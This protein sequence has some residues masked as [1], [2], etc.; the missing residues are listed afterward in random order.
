M[1]CPDSPANV[2]DLLF[3]QSDGLHSEPNRPGADPTRSAGDT[4]MNV[5]D[6][7]VIV[8]IGYCLVRGIFRGLIKE[9]SAIVGVLAGFW[10]AYS[11]YPT[12]ARPLGRWISDPAY[13]NILGFMILFCGVF[14][15]VS[16]VGVVIKYL[17]RVA[18]LGWLDRIC[19]AAFG[20]FKGVLI[21][22]VVLMALTAFLPKGTGLIRDSLLAPQVTR[23]SENLARVTPRDLKAQF[24]VKLADLRQ[25]WHEGARK[26]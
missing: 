5:F 10:I 4:H 11:Y 8:V 6:L 2:T 26:K 20:L 12:V 3:F 23:L 16:V 22:A 9:V 13:L 1:T 14:I 21:T 18:F 17:L 24:G 19:G 25:T 7:F 15:L